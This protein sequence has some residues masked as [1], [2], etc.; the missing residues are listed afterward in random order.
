M[1]VI[2]SW[3]RSHYF[4]D[5]TH[6]FVPS[7]SIWCA[8]SDIFSW[9]ELPGGG[10]APLRP[11]LQVCSTALRNSHRIKTKPSLK[12]QVGTQVFSL[13]ALLTSQIQVSVYYSVCPHVFSALIRNALLFIGVRLCSSTYCFPLGFC[14]GWWFCCFF[15]DTVLLKYETCNLLVRFLSVHHSGLLWM[16]L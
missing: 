13:P 12:V 2:S 14:L 11:T 10:Q 8:T 6:E 3:R 16:E 7:P 9:M 1:S 5:F 15:R 4:G